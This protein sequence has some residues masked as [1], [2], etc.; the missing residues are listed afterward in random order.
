[1]SAAS[2]RADG[3]SAGYPGEL[4]LD[5][6]DLQITAGDT[7]VGV[8]GPSGVG[9]TTLA[10]ALL[11]RIRPSAGAVTYQGRAVHRLPRKEKRRFAGEVR[12]VSQYSMTISDP[13]IT[14]G[15]VI[16]RALGEARKAGRTHTTPIEDLLGAVDLAPRFVDRRL[17]T[18]SG[19]ERQRVAL[20]N[21][22]ATRPEILLLDE[23]L[24]A[25][26]PQARRIMGGR[27]RQIATTL[28][29]GVLLL[30]HDLDLVE[31]LCPQVHVLAEG[32]LV[33]SGP[34][35]E[36]F[37]RSTHPVVRDLVEAAPVANQPFRP[38]R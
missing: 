24:T 22:L 9:K 30:S 29:S 13:K 32:K 10:Q 27:I 6:I 2:L 8:I 25:V 14:A 36:I 31:Q 33:A 37:A 20:A 5:G 23:P 11:G 3:L 17:I 18:L 7:P 28:G 26:D 19:G 38:K 12:S 16:K 1:M 4:V 15:Q 34:L 21:A 35:R